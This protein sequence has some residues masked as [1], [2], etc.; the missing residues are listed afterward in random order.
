MGVV[1]GGLETQS[2][3]METSTKEPPAALPIPLLSLQNP[4]DDVQTIEEART[5]IK[6]L[7][8]R[9]RFQ[10]HQTLMWR[11]KAKMQVYNAKN[12][13]ASHVTAEIRIRS[14]FS[15]RVRGETRVCRR[16]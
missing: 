7:R 4:D 11:K 8:D 2:S 3:V 16:L 1:E 13:R 5:V 15:I 12:C 6:Q 14:P 9:C 10:T